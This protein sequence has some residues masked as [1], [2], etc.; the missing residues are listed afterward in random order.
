MNARRLSPLVCLLACLLASLAA[1]AQVTV[2]VHLASVHSQPGYNN[3]NPGVYLQAGNGITLGTYRNSVRAQS[4]YLAYT[5]HSAPQAWAGDARL[6]LS[7][8]AVSGYRGP[9]LQP[10]LVPSMAWP[11]GRGS[12]VRLALI[13][14]PPRDA[15]AAALHLAV[16]VVLP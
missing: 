2:G 7:M 16:E 5:L 10:L 3:T 4:S 15:A 1:K 8:G 11:V 13:P 14:K 12:A 6:S 9:L